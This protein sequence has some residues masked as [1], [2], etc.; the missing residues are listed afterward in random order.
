M[1]KSKNKED[2]KQYKLLQN[3]YNNALRYAKNKCHEEV[4]VENNL[5]PSKF[6]STI[7]KLF[8][9]AQPPY[10]DN[11]PNKKEKVKL[12]AY[13]FSSVVEELKSKAMP[14]INFTWKKPKIMTPRTEEL[15]EFHHASRIFVFK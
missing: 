4:H 2:W 3:K 7:K 13:W 10:T 1:I 9:K 8:P 6:W 14:L 12:L 11:H 15:F 5:N